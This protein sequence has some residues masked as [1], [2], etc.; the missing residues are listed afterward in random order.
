[1][2]GAA[3]CVAVLLASCVVS[4]A[5]A[6]T[7]SP[8]EAS[9]TRG[10][11][12]AATRLLHDAWASGN[13]AVLEAQLAPTYALTDSRGRVHD[14]AGVLAAARR[15]D[16]DLESTES[17][18][19]ELRVTLAGGA[20]VVTGVS[21]ERLHFTAREEQRRRRFT[22]VWVAVDGGWQLIATHESGAESSK[23][24]SAPVMRERA[25]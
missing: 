16:V 24:S 13:V 15:H 12:L 23:I 19:T 21:E 5:V 14:R 18:L 2:S 8:A 7:P 9:A 4:A 11:L 22:E 25:H 1:M 10:A 17:S 20:G 3:R 6:S